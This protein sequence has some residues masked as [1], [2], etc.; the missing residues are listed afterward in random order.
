[1]NNITDWI[2][3]ELYPSLFEIIDSA[4]PEHN[5]KKFSNGWKSKTYINGTPHKDRD[6]KTVVTK[7]APGLIL[8][9]GG[10]SITLIDYVMRRDNI[11]FITSVRKLSNIIGL[12]MPSVD[13]EQSFKKIRI[14]TSIYEAANSYFIYCLEN[15]KPGKQI[16]NYLT[17]RGYS[18]DEVR[19]MELGCI[20]S[21]QMLFDYLLNK[22]FSKED[23]QEFIKFNSNIGVTHQLSIPYRSG[24][25]IKGFKFRTISDHTPKYLNST[26]LDRNGGFF[27]LTNVKGDK[28]IIIVE[29]ELDCL[30]ASVKGIENIVA[31]GGSSV[32]ETQIED[33]IKKGAK[34]FTICLDNEPNKEEQTYKNVYSIISKI[35]ESGVNR[36]YIV[37]LPLIDNEKTDPDRFIKTKGVEEFKNLIYQALPYY[38]Y[39]LEKVFEKYTKIYNLNNALTFKDVDNLKEDIVTLSLSIE[40]INK[41]MFIES[42]S[43]NQT[44]RDLGITR[45]SL[46]ITLDRIAVSKNKEKQKENFSSLMSKVN[47]YKDAGNIEKAI[48]ILETNITQVKLQSKENEFGKLLNSTSEQEVKNELSNKPGSLV[49]SFE[50]DNERL[51]I[52]SGAISILAAPTSHGKT[53]LLLNLMIDTVLRNKDKSFYFFSYEEDKSSVLTSALSIFHK[54]EVSKNNRRSIYSY[55]AS[56]T[57]EYM[58]NDNS[59]VSSFMNSKKTFFKELIDTNRLNIQYSNYDIDTLCEAIIY[60][61]KNTNIGGVYID[62]IQL[63]NLPKGKYK[64]YSRQEEIKEICI[65]L[66]DVAVTT[67]LP[68]VLGAQFNRQVTNHLKIHSTNIGEAGDIERIANLILGFWNNNFSPIGSE[69]EIKEIKEKDLDKHKTI[70]VSVL[71]NRGGRAGASDFFSYNGNTGVIE[72]YFS[73]IKDANNIFS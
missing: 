55:F 40:P 43:E 11:D 21:Q 18:I 19:Q 41:D 24:G 71:K 65:K 54:D 13:D 37:S 52:P 14:S 57:F 1:M 73:D 59:V 32:N 50:I 61:N 20:P 45:E 35:L 56:N 68:I 70:Y 67:G 22:D 64:T 47:S 2:K 46:E 23:I 58:Y 6:D 3:N 8:E 60:L 10:E 31:T 17:E 12:T 39:Q 69:G 34:S 7:K 28:D 29:G 4:F 25:H 30:H 44:M 63:L 27:N 26:G 5:F 16:L 51:H 36:V 72:N 48:E 53:T 9:Q 66:K 49:T 15:S 38:E 42:L 62:Y 33:A